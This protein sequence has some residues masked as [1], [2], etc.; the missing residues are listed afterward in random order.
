MEKLQGLQVQEKE[1][2][3][4][5][6]YTVLSTSSR[7]QEVLQATNCR[8]VVYHPLKVDNIFILRLK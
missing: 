1:E 6:L 5:K 3:Y 2:V 8:N 4:M 7:F